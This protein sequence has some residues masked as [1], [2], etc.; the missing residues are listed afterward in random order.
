MT[1]VQIPFKR[2]FKD[3]EN[4]FEFRYTICI[5]VQLIFCLM[6]F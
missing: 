2:N 1:P 3:M 6:R 5:I 4:K